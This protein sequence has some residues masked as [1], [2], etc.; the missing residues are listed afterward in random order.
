[1][2]GYD[3]D[4]AAFCIIYQIISMSLCMSQAPLKASASMYSSNDGGHSSLKA[5]DQSNLIICHAS[6]NSAH[7]RCLM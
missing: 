7:P 5:S 4:N 6:T 1:M 2:S 3:Y